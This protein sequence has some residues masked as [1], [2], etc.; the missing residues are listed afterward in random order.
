MKNYWPYIVLGGIP[1]WT[2]LMRPIYP[3]LALVFI[4]P[5]LPHPMRKLFL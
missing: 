1:S 2:G 3:A 4:V 5:F